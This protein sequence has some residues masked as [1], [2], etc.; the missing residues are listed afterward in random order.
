MKIITDI[1]ID[2]SDKTKS[3]ITIKYIIS[4]KHRETNNPS[5]SYWIVEYIEE[6][7][8]FITNYVNNYKVENL[9]W[10]LIQEANSLKVLGRNIFKEELKLAKFIDSSK[11]NI[12]HGYPAD[13]RRKNHDRPCS[14]VLQKWVKDKIIT[15]SKM[16]KIRQGQTCNL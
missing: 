7:Q 11:N 15:K 4:S 8:C 6:L 2:I 10:G 14:V 13:Y 1:E 5:K 3:D 12:W 9:T 16:L